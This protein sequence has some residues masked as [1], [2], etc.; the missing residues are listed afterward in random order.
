MVMVPDNKTKMA[1]M[2]KTIT[3]P[4]NTNLEIFF[5]CLVLGWKEQNDVWV[6]INNPILQILY[7]EV[8]VFNLDIAIEGRA[9]GKE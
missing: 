2:F 1:V 5:T 8:V 3:V 9:D 7:D 6:R 4:A